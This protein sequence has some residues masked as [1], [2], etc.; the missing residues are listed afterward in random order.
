MMIKFHM[1][2]ILKNY[3]K[4]IWYL[5]SFYL[6]HLTF[7]CIVK[8][9]IETKLFFFESK[10]F[11][12]ILSIFIISHNEAPGRKYR[13]WTFRSILYN[14]IGHLMREIWTMHFMFDAKVL[15]HSFFCDD[16]NNLSTCWAIWIYEHPSYIIYNFLYSVF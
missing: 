8:L 7:K 10:A 16:N 1:K 9:M 11:P 13:Y 4:W 15:Y 2:E 5:S 14:F 12:S 3:A 6:S